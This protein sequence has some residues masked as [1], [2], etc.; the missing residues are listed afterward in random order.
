MKGLRVATYR[1]CRL[2]CVG[3]T[4]FYH[5]DCLRKVE[6][7]YM[8]AKINDVI[9][10][11][12]Q[13]TGDLRNTAALRDSKECGQ[14][15]QQSKVSSTARHRLTPVAQADLPKPRNFRRQRKVSN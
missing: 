9:G 2:L 14:L 13:V 4:D 3:S 11:A 12:G 1:R 8:A 10:S 7:E 15:L 5:K 6:E